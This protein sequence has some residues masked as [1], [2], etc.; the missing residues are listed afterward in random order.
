MQILGSQGL[1]VNEMRFTRDELW[2]A[3]EVFLTGSAAEVTPIRE[4]DG[5]VIGKGALAGK[6][7][8]V[9]SQ[10]Q[11]DFKAITSGEIKPE[12]ARNWLTSVR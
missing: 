2:C 5:R 10:L 11:K 9:A 6:V 3:D 1:Q 8:P 12:Y 7:G 4:I